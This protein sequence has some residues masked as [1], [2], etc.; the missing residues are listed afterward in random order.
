MFAK[1]ITQIIETHE[2]HLGGVLWC[3]SSAGT[4]SVR[5]RSTTPT[6]NIAHNTYTAH[7]IISK[8]F[9]QLGHNIYGTYTWNES[10]CRT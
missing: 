1:Q 5:I 2:A 9:V 7:G 4:H 3:G 6:P 10:T 8:G